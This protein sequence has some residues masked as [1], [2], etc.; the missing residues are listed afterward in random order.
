MRVISLFY[1]AGGMDSGFA[2]AGHTILWANDHDAD[3][4]RT[5][6]HNISAHAQIGDVESVLAS[7]I[8]DGD[9]RSRPLLR[10]SRGTRCES[11]LPSPTRT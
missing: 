2:E 5:Y 6:E 9:P 8:P 3:A 11:A 7:D 1:G 4:L 10:R